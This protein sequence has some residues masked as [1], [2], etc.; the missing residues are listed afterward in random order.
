MS[1]C[2][3]TDIRQLDLE[4]NLLTSWTQVFEITAQL[5]R[6]HELRLTNNHLVHLDLGE[7]RA[8]AANRSG[9]PTGE[10]KGSQTPS[11]PAPLCT[12]R[13]LIVDN[14]PYAWS[15]VSTLCNSRSLGR[16]FS[17][18]IVRSPGVIVQ[19]CVISASGLLPC[20]EELYLSRN[21]LS[22]LDPLVAFP[23]PPPAPPHT[24]PS[25]LATPDTPASSSS[26]T[27]KGS[28]TTES[29]EPSS[30]APPPAA[31]PSPFA[32]LV[33]SAPVMVTGETP[34][35]HLSPQCFPHLQVLD[36]SVNHLADWQE[37]NRLS[38][39]PK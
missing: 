18:R 37:I 30:A 32:S 11:N 12:V 19:V 25:L 14:V 3:C 34:S 29:K 9:Q 20:L 10:S 5:P 15:A 39:L 23:L 24:S 2:T 36:L 6:L 16:S 7:I 38:L 8:L 13:S 26:S 21:N 31:F 4:G 22:S 27:A 35:F 28:L 17:L 1:C 33:A